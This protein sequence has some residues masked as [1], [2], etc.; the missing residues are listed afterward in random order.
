MGRLLAGLVVSL[1]VLAAFS[2][3]A[4]GA[5]PLAGLG[6]VVGCLVMLVVWLAHLWARERL[7]AK[8]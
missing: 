8:R 2:S 5:P 6:A 4:Y 7:E 1:I 3:L